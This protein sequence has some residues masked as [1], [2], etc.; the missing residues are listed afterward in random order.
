LLG[1]Y[2]RFIDRK[3][4]IFFKEKSKFH[5]GNIGADGI[6]ER[7]SK[8]IHLEHQ[9]LA[10]EA[11]FTGDQVTFL[12][13]CDRTTFSNE[14]LARIGIAQRNSEGRLHFIHRT[15]AEFFVAHFLINRL[16]KKT[17]QHV[18]VKELLLNEVLLRRDCHVIRAFLNGLLENSE[19]S[20]EALK[21]YGEKLQEEWNKRNVHGQIII[22]TA[23]LN[24]AA[25]EDT[26][27]IVGFLLDSLKSGQ[28]SYAVNIMLTKGSG[29]RTAWHTAV[30]FSSLQA[31]EKIW[32][33]VELVAPTQ[34]H[35]L[36]L[37]QDIY[38]RTALRQAI[39]NGNIE[40]AE[41]L[42]VWGKA[43]MTPADLK[44]EMFSRHNRLAIT[45]W[46]EVAKW[47]RVKC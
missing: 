34:T 21:E 14:E 47:G 30:R 4:D 1:L 7:E 6:Q 27:C 3:Y 42:R 38:S 44:N 28:H 13:S 46:H 25:R 35:S 33:W 29:I 8:N 23:A 19:P 24:E 43:K 15:F 36:F 12:Q 17:K 2:R 37:S 41:K 5:P 16:T 45:A 32:E 20:K 9:L 26:A 22:E 31:L 18:Q 40:L 11:L 10:L 39:E